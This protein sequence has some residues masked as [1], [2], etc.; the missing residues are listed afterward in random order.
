MVK[1]LVKSAFLRAGLELRRHNPAYMPDVQL[2]NVLRRK[3]IDI[4]FDVG[5]NI[6]QY[7]GALRE[8]GYAGTIVS[9]EPLS[10]AHAALT[11]AA[12]DDPRWQVAPRGA[13]G[14]TDGEIAINVAG[15]SVSSSVLDMLGSHAEAAP[16]S[17]YTGK[18]SVPIR[19]LDTIADHWLAEDSRLFLKADTQGFEG[20]VL[21][22][23]KAAL[24]RTHAVQLELSLTPLY[25]GQ[26]MAE[27]IIARLRAAGFAPWTLW[28][29]FADA[30]TGRLLQIDAI[31]VRED[32]A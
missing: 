8:L 16:D 14:A 28:P 32:A 23:A 11:V 22:G 12:A 6:G 17:S 24:A 13:I 20:A 7:G 15:N 31:F 2:M 3:R 30:A 10:S 29:G 21:E 4:V 27:D 25:E 9:F 19:R 1:R 26:L 18:E 5:A